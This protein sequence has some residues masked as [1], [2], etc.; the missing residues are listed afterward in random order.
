MSD[1][2]IR[3]LISHHLKHKKSA[4]LTA[5]KYRNPKGILSIS[6][7]FEINQIKEKPIEYINGGFFVLNNNIFKFLKDDKSVFET[8]CLERLSRI[9]QL[10]A[11]KHKGFW[12][13]MDTMREKLEINK[14]WKSKKAPWKV[15]R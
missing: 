4:T 15:W 11:Y 1:I 14:I 5:V 8:D 6:K 10:L 3:K 2:N 7:N 13:C 12:A 9:N